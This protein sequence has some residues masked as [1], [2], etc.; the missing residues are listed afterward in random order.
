ML[1]DLYQTPAWRTSPQEATA[2]PASQ[3]GGKQAEIHAAEYGSNEIQCSFTSETYLREIFPMTV[4]DIRCIESSIGPEVLKPEMHSL[5]FAQYYFK[6]VCG[7]Q[8]RRLA[9]LR[10]AQTVGTR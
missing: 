5:E 6:R 3:A 9:L 8:L 4:P 10:L 1:L 7:S 2:W